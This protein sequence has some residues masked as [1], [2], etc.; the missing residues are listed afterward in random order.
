[1]EGGRGTPEIGGW[2]SQWAVT[3][4]RV[5]ACGAEAGQGRCSSGETPSHPA[6]RPHFRAPAPPSAENPDGGASAN[7]APGVHT[8]APP[9]SPVKTRSAQLPKSDVHSEVKW[10]RR[11][12][13]RSDLQQ[14][15][16]LLA[17]VSENDIRQGPGRQAEDRSSRTVT[18]TPAPAEEEA[19]CWGRSPPRAGTP[20]SAAG[21]RP[22]AVSTPGLGSASASLPTWRPHLPRPPQPARVFRVPP[23]GG[24]SAGPARRQV[25]PAWRAAGECPGGRGEGG[26]SPGRGPSGAGPARGGAG[27]ARGV[28]GMGGV[29]STGVGGR[30]RGRPPWIPDWPPPAGHLGGRRAGS[31]LRPSA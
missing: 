28:G 25:H 31:Q 22:C 4:G 27:P 16:P 12:S 24:T 14:H 8:G 3:K 30:G 15:N 9:A 29:V 18:A 1:M 19:R 26:A 11:S 7:T 23:A 10:R 13:S 17:K 2:G 5:R 21:P 6:S 20:G